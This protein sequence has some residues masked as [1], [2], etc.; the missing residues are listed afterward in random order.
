MDMKNVVDEIKE[1]ENERELHIAE[2]KKEYPIEDFIVFS[3][4]DLKDKI[5]KLSMKLLEYQELLYKE[6]SLLDKIKE[7]RN[8]IVGE[9]YNY[10]RFDFDKELTKYEIKEYYL[11]NDPNILAFDKTVRKQT[12]TVE[13]FEGCVKAIEKMTWTVKD[14]LKTIAQGSGI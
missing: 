2:L 14:Y 10:Y 7:Q 3:E 5:E 13:F 6:Q 12:W 8:R 9:R 1:H 4:F 11:T